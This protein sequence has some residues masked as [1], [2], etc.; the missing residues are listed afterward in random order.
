[1]KITKLSNKR[2]L[3]EFPTR[4]E[5]TLSNF[6]ISEFYEGKEGIK[7][8]SWTPDKF[9]DLYSDENGRIEYFE[10]WEGFNYPVKSINDFYCV[11]ESDV[12]DSRLSDREIKILEASKQIDKDG[13]I[14]SCVEG[15]EITLKHETAHALFFENVEYRNKV[16]E[17]INTLDAETISKFRSHLFLMRY[18]EDVLIDEMQ[19]YLIAFDDEE[20]LECFGSITEDEIYSHRSNLQATFDYYNK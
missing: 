8:C 6:R 10:F 2:L 5:M 11:F 7:G 18:N 3:L 16:T 14:I 13:Y 9:I 20:W 17:I 15:D 4:K 19:A 1:M 12:E